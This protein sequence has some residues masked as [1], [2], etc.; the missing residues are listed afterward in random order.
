MRLFIWCY[1][2]YKPSWL[3]SAIRVHL[4]SGAVTKGQLG[5]A[6]RGRKVV[7]EASFASQRLRIWRRC[8]ILRSVSHE[9][10]RVHICGVTCLQAWKAAVI[11]LTDMRT[12]HLCSSEIVCTRLHRVT[13]QKTIISGGPEVRYNGRV[14]SAFHL[15]LD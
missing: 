4:T 6:V 3:L 5:L 14:H 13:F 2:T 7:N 9:E 15:T 1:E 11:N 10:H 12:A 8:E